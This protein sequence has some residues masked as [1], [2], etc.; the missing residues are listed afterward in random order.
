MADQ[1]SA[2]KIQEQN[3]ITDATE[4]LGTRCMSSRAMVANGKLGRLTVHQTKV[5]KL[6]W[7]EKS[8]DS[9]KVRMTNEASTAVKTVNI[10]IANLVLYVFI[11]V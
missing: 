2:L 3:I 9:A 8:N 11:N 5:R 6:L 7:T 1:T 4:S 10:R